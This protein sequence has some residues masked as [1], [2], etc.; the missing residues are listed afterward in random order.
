[1]HAPLPKADRRQRSRPAA[2]GLFGL[3]EDGRDQVVAVQS[4]LLAQIGAVWPFTL[5]TQLVAGV[6]LIVIAAIDGRGAM[7]PLIGVYVGIVAIVSLAL[8]ATLRV[9]AM[10]R[11]PAHQRYRILT[12]GAAGLAAGLLAL[13]WTTTRMPVG[14]VQLGCFVAVSGAIGVTALSIHPV[15]VATLGFGAG[16]VL[17]LAILSGISLAFAVAVL[18]LGC[19]ALVAHRLAQVDHDIALDRVDEGSEGRLAVKMIAEFESHGTGWFWEADRHGRVTYISA[20]VAGELTPTGGSPAG[21]LLTDLFRMDSDSTERTLAFHLSSR[22][23]FADYS[24]RAAID[25]PIDT[26]SPRWWSISGRPLVDEIGRFQGFIGSGSD[27]T[28]KRKSEAEITRLALFDGLTGLANRQRM[29]LTL[30]KTLAQQAGPHRPTGLFL[31]DLDR[32]KAVNDT[33]GHQAGDALLKQ[34]A[35]RLQRGV[36]DAGLVGRLGGDEFKVVLPGIDNREQLAVLARDLI[37]SLSQPYFISGAS[38]AI[39]CSI[40]IAVAPEHGEDSET[41]VRNA[42]L[43]L[44]AAKG[45][46]RGIHR[47]YSDDMLAGAKSRKQLEDDLRTA[48][49]D[50]AFHL[51]YQPVVSTKTARIVGYEALIRWTH[52]TR[53]NVSPADFI[54]IA[55]ESGLIEGIG[56]WVLRTACLEAARWPGDIRVAVNVSPIQFANPAL[57]ALVTSALAHSG[58]APGRLELEITEGVFL[59]ETQSSDQMFK[60]LKGIG[61]RL[62]LDDF[63]T[64]YSSL[65]YLRNAPFDKIKIDQSFVKGAAQSGNRNAAI[66]KAIV[67]LADTLGMETTAEGVEIQ[68]EIDLIRDLGCSHIQGYVYG[69]P[70]PAD[71]VLVQLGGQ[72]GIAKP[73]GFKVSRSPR[74][75]ML[76]SARIAIDGARGDVRI[77]DIS[78]KGAMIDGI[79]IEGDPAGIEMQIELLEDQMITARIRWAKDGKAGIEFAEAFNLDRLTPAQVS[80]VLRRSA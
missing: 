51:A 12:A 23:S 4:A 17:M 31:M 41:L 21:M 38:V 65:G 49:S 3:G 13:L 60:A 22:T 71:E 67:T 55:E 47:F 11:W 75:K 72:A 2:Y 33:L 62:A 43:A 68:D 16:V 64:G 40:G 30:D 37:T 26:D 80:R 66:I 76:R 35:Q 45:D 14:T 6:L 15:R 5:A 7:L 46:G 79:A 1:M 36:G 8:L 50:G 56:E 78:T 48:V 25:P 74:T 9:P 63:G 32:F 19:L 61:V 27:L 44:Y 70:A 57:P 34:V 53:G 20:K 10:R 77:R 24:V 18:F 58:I 28:E 39:G 52:P 42:D 59:D 29:R 54:P 69:R 73:S